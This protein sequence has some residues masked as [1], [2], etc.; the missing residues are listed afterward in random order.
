M[1]TETLRY[2]AG[3]TVSSAYGSGADAKG[4]TMGLTVE[5]WVD[6]F[7]R[8][9]AIETKYGKAQCRS[10][11]VINFNASVVS[12]D[13]DTQGP[14]ADL[15]ASGSLS[16]YVNAVGDGEGITN[17]SRFVGRVATATTTDKTCTAKTVA[18][19]SDVAGL[20]PTA[21]AY[22][23]S[24]TLAGAAYW[25][26]THA[27]RATPAPTSD[28]TDPNFRVN[29]YSVALA[30]G[31]PRITVSTTDGKKAVIQPTYNLNLGAGRIG[32]GTLV[33][34]RVVSQTATSGKYLVVWE[35]SEQGGDYDQDAS[36]I[37]EWSLSGT[38]LSVT[39]ST[40]ADATSNGQGFG[41]T[42]SGTNKDGVHFH[43][44][45]LGF[46]F[47]D[48]TGLTVTKIDGTAHPNVN[49]TGGCSNCQKN[50]PPSRATYTVTGQVGASLEDPLWYA[51]KWG[52][53]KVTMSD[54]RVA[55]LPDTRSKWDTKDASGKV[56]IQPDGTLGDG[57]PDNYFVV[58]NP[59]QLEVALRAVFGSAVGS[60]NAAPA[61]SSS[62][63]IA[64]GV[65]YLAKF[66]SNTVS[67]NVDAYKIKPD[68]TFETASVWNAGEQLSAIAPDSRNIITNNGHTGVEFNWTT[69]SALTD[70]NAALTSGSTAV[71]TTAQARQT[72]Q[73]MRGVR[74]DEG[75]SDEALRER[76]RSPN[77]ILG[78]VVSAAPWIQDRPIARFADSRYPGYS[79]FA[80]DKASRQKVLWVASDDGMVHAFQAYEGTATSG[81][82]LFSYAPGALAQRFNAIPRK[83]F[84]V[85][86]FVDGS[87]FAADVWI[88]DTSIPLVSNQWHT[89]LFGSLGRGG[90]G[91]YALDVTTP[92]ALTQANA[93]SIF[94]WEFTADTDSDLGYVLSD[95]SI[96][97]T[98]GQAAP[99]AKLNNGKFALIVGNG[100][101]SST[102]HAALFIIPAD[103]PTAAGSW[104]NRYSKIVADG[105]ST[106]NG[107]ST[108]T[109]VDLDNNGTADVVYAGD[110]KG[111]LWK[112]DIS[113][114]D[115]A[116]WKV[117]YASTSNVPE[118]LYVATGLPI[119]AAP[120]YAF[121]P[122]G[123]VHVTFA[124][125]LS[126]T[127]T[128]YPNTT[129]TQRVY[130]I[131]DRPAFTVT[132][133]TT[134]RPRAL[135]RGV[136]TL[137]QRVYERL[138]NGQVIVRSGASVD[139]TNATPSLSKDG[140][141]FN[142]PG[143]SEMVVTNL[144]YRLN[145][146]LMTSIRPAA[147][148]ATSCSSEPEATLYV[149]EPV[150]GA[151]T[152]KTLGTVTDGT[153]TF[154]VAGIPVDDQKLRYANDRTS[155][156]FTPPPPKSCT[157]GSPNCECKMVNAAEVCEEQDPP[158]CT[159][160]ASLRAIGRD[161]DSS[162]CFNQS[163]AR[164]QWREIPGMRT[165]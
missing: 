107:L 133:V 16:S 158:R 113:S 29:S 125:G 48:P 82:A 46:N 41:Y 76:P 24:Y 8:G 151:P 148:A 1:F 115:P 156:P 15:G 119:T 83:G 47:T 134:P 122:F 124:T 71:Q 135:P 84:P 51:A 7:T 22:E 11:D 126:N 164:F 153:T 130:G 160:N 20:C 165:K 39:T 5:A 106:D 108:P 69:L 66:D 57:T 96:E 95:I 30:P 64:G 63:L 53:Y 114:S 17:T 50:Q 163:N 43:S 152:S 49:G 26:H 144:E 31:V 147:S 90:R 116:N 89:Y 55:D 61:V 150:T 146:I 123:G 12:Y 38:T 105:T 121:P 137:V 102:G 128:E 138:S 88:N 58:F 81:A 62:Q 18:N 149:F 19:L 70:Y 97:P 2:L 3:K 104:T 6:P 45:I 85:T 75:T 140:W 40:F 13:K 136:S 157:K 129:A 120:Q 77:N 161:T 28:V 32:N 52:G 103:G 162:L 35:D 93:A 141:Y 142:L 73:Y 91:L 94:K 42:I 54:T 59:D 65:K 10:I 118:P 145:N 99:V 101:K 27:I 100:Y 112:F 44:G 72:I 14:F 67:G 117:A 74:S 159:G 60:S 127:S 143:T 86:A 80:A 4:A 132:P 87:P 155:L 131:W 37:L 9:A 68:G 21:P 78:P 25:A 56:V 79:T 154:L 109:W 34:F 36:G 139:Y 110:L 33:D 98:T 111:N 92:S 23:G